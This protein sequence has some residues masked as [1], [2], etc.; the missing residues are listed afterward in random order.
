ML[1]A[2]Q[3][4]GH[5]L[6][7]PAGGELVVGIATVCGPKTE[8][9]IGFPREPDLIW[10]ALRPLPVSL[11]GRKRGAYAAWPARAAC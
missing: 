1:V 5:V 8:H 3:W 7:G 9:L 6:A 10:T 2:G 4:Q 11:T